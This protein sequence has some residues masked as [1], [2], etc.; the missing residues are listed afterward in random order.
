MRD[1]SVDLTFHEGASGSK[2]KSGKKNKKDRTSL[3]VQEGKIHKEKTC[4]ICKK[5]GYF[6]K[7]CPKRKKWFEKKGTYYVSIG[8]ESNLIEVPNNT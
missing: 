3:K 4:F 5:A 6:K 8:F 1:H 7:D 2:A